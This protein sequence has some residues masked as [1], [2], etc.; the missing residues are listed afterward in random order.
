M[1]KLELRQIIREEIKRVLREIGEGTAKPYDYKY[2]ADT[3]DAIYYSFTTDPDPKKTFLGQ[4]APGTEY[5]V[6]LRYWD[7]E[8]NK[9]S[10]TNIDVAFSTHGGEYE[11]ETND[12]VQYRV[13]ATVAAIV[14]EALKN[15]PDITTLTFTPSKADKMDTRRARFYK[16]YVEKQLPGSTVTTLKDGGFKLQLT[17]R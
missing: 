6:N 7:I 5:E 11:E 4:P 8:T 10:F 3:N 14:K 12:N 9:R 16:A 17:S 15:H 2:I 13:M 1:K